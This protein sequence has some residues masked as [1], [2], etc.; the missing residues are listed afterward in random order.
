MRFIFFLILSFCFAWVLIWLIFIWAFY[1]SDFSI[2]DIDFFSVLPI[3][4]IRGIIFWIIAT[5]IL[6]VASFLYG[7]GKKS[8]NGYFILFGWA[9]LII[10]LFLW[11]S[12]WFDL[13]K[14]Y[15]WE[16]EI[17]QKASF[18]I[19]DTSSGVINLDISKMAENYWIEEYFYYSKT[20]IK[21]KAATWS[22]LTIKVNK[23]IIWSENLTDRIINNFN[24]IN[25]Q[26]EDDTIILNYENNKAFKSKVPLTMI[27]NDV[28]IYLPKNY[29]YN[30]GYNKYK[31]RYY[32]ENIF[33]NNDFEQYKD[34]I[35]QDCRYKTI[36]YSEVEDNFVCDLSDSEIKSVKFLMLKTNLINKFES[37]STIK[38][39]DKYKNTYRWDY[40][41]KS[42]WSF[43]NI[44][45][46]DDDTVII[47]FWDRSLDI[48]AQVD[49]KENEDWIL[50]FSNFKINNVDANYA[51]Q[52]K[53]YQDI[54]AIKDFI[55][56]EE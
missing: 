19:L 41:M 24:E 51:Y 26:K 35:N 16:S 3:Y 15:I 30:L 20:N 23:K 44:Y 32:Y 6:G 53:Y 54:S 46:L 45:N 25:L 4:F 5:A 1:F 9:S 55:N 52:E 11:I 43:D 47:E 29:Q 40:N 14:T 48:N 36:Y 28:T 42:D 22:L 17:T 27:D 12:S 49:Y 39:V 13:A 56:E 33:V 37:F 21:I 8:L 50:E 31:H 10:A 2:Y 34:Y 18:E 7:I 38:H